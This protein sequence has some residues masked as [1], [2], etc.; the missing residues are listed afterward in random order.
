M[1]SARIKYILLGWVEE[2]LGE[3]G[4]IKGGRRNL[5]AS[6][7]NIFPKCALHDPIAQ[8]SQGLKLTFKHEFKYDS[9]RDMIQP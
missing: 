5:W 6:L 7:W 3:K 9:K 8:I 1:T 2:S 4:G